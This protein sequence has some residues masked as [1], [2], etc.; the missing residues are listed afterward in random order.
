MLVYLLLASN[1]TSNGSGT[2]TISNGTV[3]NS[4]VTITGAAN[5]TTYSAGYGLLVEQLLHLTHIHFHRLVPKATE[6]T[7]VAGKA[8]EIGRLG[9]AD[10]VADMAILV[11]QM[12]YLDLIL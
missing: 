6:I 4:T 8:T 9:T 1:H 7:T 10:A 12:L 3:G 5:N 2:F 11:Q